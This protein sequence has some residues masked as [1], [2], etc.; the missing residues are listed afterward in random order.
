MKQPDKT[1]PR[2]SI[3]LREVPMEPGCDLPP[4][5]ALQYHSEG[6]R[7]LGPEVMGQRV[8]ESQALPLGCG[9][10]SNRQKESI[11]GVREPLMALRGKQ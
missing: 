9:T 8:C 5:S 6:H 3:P 10:Q 2:H 1:G 4:Q 11:K 7:A